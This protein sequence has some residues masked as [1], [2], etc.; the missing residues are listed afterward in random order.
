MNKIDE[1]AYEKLFQKVSKRQQIKLNNFKFNKEANAWIRVRPCIVEGVRFNDLELTLIIKE[2][3][4][5]KIINQTQKCRQCE[6]IM[7]EYVDHAHL[8]KTGNGRIKRHDV[9][10][11]FIYDQVPA[12][13]I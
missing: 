10:K 8:C 2:R 7:E 1:K 11:D 5:C 3:L 12:I 9:L 4:G 6:H 13:T